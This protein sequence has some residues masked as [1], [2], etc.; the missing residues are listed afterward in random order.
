MR[1]TD[2]KGSLPG[3]GGGSGRYIF[4]HS[5]PQPLSASYFD[6]LPQPEQ[7][8]LIAAEGVYISVRQE[9]EFI[10]RLYRLGSFHVELFY[11]Q[12]SERP[13]CIRIK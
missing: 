10:I 9:P 6:S 3:G 8:A 5:T 12:I 2:H 1:K 4:L 11:H 7:E 13:V